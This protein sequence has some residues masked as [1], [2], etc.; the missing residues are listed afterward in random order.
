MVNPLEMQPRVREFGIENVNATLMPWNPIPFAPGNFVKV[1]A[2]DRER[3][4]VDFLFKQEAHAEF[5]RHVHLCTSVTLTLE[6]R[7][8]YRE[9]DE[10]HFTGT[11]MYEPPGTT[12]TPFAHEEGAVLYQ[13]FTGPQDGVFIELLDADGAVIG[14]VELS[15]FERFVE[16]R[17]ETA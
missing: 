9:G 12:H 10:T 6:G 7:W 13:S 2:I 15:F 8:G 3:G 17:V 11:F 16:E 4:R 5:P 1:L 14:K